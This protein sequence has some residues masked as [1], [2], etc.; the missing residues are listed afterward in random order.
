MCPCHQHAT[1]T[2]RPSVTQ[3][4]AAADTDDAPCREPRWSR[5]RRRPHR[6]T[7]QLPRRR[8]GRPA[9]LPRLTPHVPLLPLRRSPLHPL[10]RLQP[11][12]HRHRP[13]HRH[14]A[15]AALRFHRHADDGQGVDSGH[16]DGQCRDV[17]RDV[18]LE[19]LDDG[20]RVLILWRAPSPVHRLLRR[21]PHLLQSRRHHRSLRRPL[22]HRLETPDPDTGKWSNVD[23][24]VDGWMD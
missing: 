18:R 24:W 11:A 22:Q 8:P 20:G 10:L 4:R 14:H 23:G 13:L 2:R 21:R 1:F 7:L 5:L 16:L 6:A 9:S 15:S 3:V 12:R 19:P 17:R